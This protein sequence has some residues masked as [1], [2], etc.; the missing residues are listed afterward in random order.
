[1]GQQPSRGESLESALAEAESEFEIAQ[2]EL[3]NATRVAFAARTRRNELLE[4]MRESESSGPD[5]RWDTAIYIT[6]Y[7]TESCYAL[8]G[9]SI[10]DDFD[11]ATALGG[12]FDFR[13]PLPS[14]EMCSYVFFFLA[15][16]DDPDR[17]RFFESAEPR[18][19]MLLVYVFF[20]AQ[21]RRAGA[22][23]PELRL[24]RAEQERGVFV[25]DLPS[26]LDSRG[27][28]TATTRGDAYRRGLRAME[29]AFTRG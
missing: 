12:E 22:L 14:D 1:M 20:N 11:V 13:R 21:P 18:A 4:R 16:P 28:I 8:F 27:K 10:P 17:L 5:P 2:Q 6:G 15:D 24:T 3:A 26:V 9:R 25:V 29:T 23:P 19:D 7:P